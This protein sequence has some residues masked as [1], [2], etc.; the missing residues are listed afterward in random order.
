MILLDIFTQFNILKNTY[1]NPKYNYKYNNNH[2]SI[3]KKLV[4]NLQPYI[5]NYED[6]RNRNILR[7]KMN[8]L[9]IDTN[10][11]N[12]TVEANK[13]FKFNAFVICCITFFC[14]IPIRRYYSTS[15]I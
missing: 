7:K 13:L 2:L 5:D 11:S 10:D 8:L 3:N 15:V 1:N 6:I 9:Y 14:I 4:S 12:Y